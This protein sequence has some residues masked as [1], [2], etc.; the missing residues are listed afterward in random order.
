MNA[1]VFWDKDSNSALLSDLKIKIGQLLTSA[2]HTHEFVAVGK[3]EIIPCTGCLKCYL[4]NNDICVNRDIMSDVNRRIKDFE[5]II[6]IGP[7]IFG[8]YSS[9]IKNVLDKN[10][11]IHIFRLGRI[12][13]LI[14]LGCSEGIIEE[15]KNTFLDIFRK[16]RGAA[17]IVHPL[18]K[19]RSEIFMTGSLNENT[20][21]IEAVANLI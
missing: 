15:E 2:G 4:T 12:P 6:Y 11:L 13:L 5:I 21:V 9:P 10:Q 8:Q 20:L 3:N 16:H 14:G 19:S 18:L 17:D 7:V 1:I